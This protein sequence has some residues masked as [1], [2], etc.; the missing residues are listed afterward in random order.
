M[1]AIV[2]RPG[3]ALPVV[4]A[5]P[6]LREALE[7]ERIVILTAPP[8]AGKSTLVP[9]E[10]RAE[11]WLFGQRITMLE[12]RRLAARTVAAR[13]ASQIGEPLGG[14][15]G[16]RIR[17]ESRVSLATRVEV[18]TEG[19]LTRA[20]LA[21]PDLGGCGLLI[22]DEFHERSIHAD[23]GLA[24]ARRV[25]AVF[26]PDL[27]ILIMSATLDEEALSRALGGVPVVKSAG[28][29][30][31]VEISHASDDLNPDRDPVPAVVAAVRRALRTVEGD[32]LAFL[33]GTSEITRVGTNLQDLASDGLDVRPLHGDLTIEAQQAAILPGPRRRVVLATNIA[34]TSLTI[35]GVRVVIDSGLAR[36][37]RFDSGLGMSRLDTVRIARDNADQRAGR[38][39]RLGPGAAFRLWTATTQK[40]LAASRAPE[41]VDADLLPLAL[42]LAVWGEADASLAW[43]TPP[44]AGPLAEARRILVGL[45]A[46]IGDAVTAHGRAIHELGV[47]PRIGHLLIE[48]RGFGLGGLAAD[49]AALLEERDILG[50]D[51]GADLSLR[52][53][54]LRG[55]GRGASGGGGAARVRDIARDHRSR[56][57][58]DPAASSGGVEDVGRLVALAYP[59]RIAQRRAGS[60]DRYRLAAGRGARLDAKDPLTHEEW[61]AVAHVDAR[62]AEGRIFLAAPLDI[63][64][65]EPEARDVIAWDSGRGVIVAQRERRIG[66]LVLDAKPRASVP[67]DVKIALLAGAIRSEGLLPQLLSDA[68]RA[69]QSRVSSLRAWGRAER[70]PDVSDAALLAALE[71]WLQSDLL[72]SRSKTDLLRLDTGAALTAIL[73]WNQQ[74]E[75]NRLAPTHIEAPTG[76][77]IELQ[78][79]PDG[80]PPVLAVRLQEIF[81]WLDTPT[82]NDGRTRVTLHL[83]SP[84]RRPVQATQDLRSFWT[85]TYPEVRKE[86]RS[87]YPR[88]SW[89][90]DPLTAPPVRGPKRRTN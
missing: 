27:R 69:F 57:K 77:R 88:H 45:G 73:D 8:G 22:F 26:R 71:E 78:Y 9:L 47:H 1:T 55:R 16:Y 29:S 59:E 28:R 2:G 25:Q 15:V 42:D 37:S 80:S 81:G 11:S 86:L 67:D 79:F 51:A 36:V 38:A 40:S 70:F 21:Q 19:I 52:V 68:A 49:I 6:A 56:L 3:P 35:E 61:L 34:E 39:G 5:L 66:E 53:E 90:D 32:I 54:A 13:M 20:L 76:S 75:L 89:P 46:M 62:D 12:P 43:I 65:I 84:A 7:R 44:Q 31:P 85:N 14:L 30:F 41:I 24:L 48:G 10:L 82:V 83:L 87:R 60:T 64:T 33:P 23:L 17:R 58:L 50:R 4:D 74:R 72:A 18:V 63:T